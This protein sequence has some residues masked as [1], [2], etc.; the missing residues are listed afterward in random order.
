MLTLAFETSCDETAAAVVDSQFNVLSNV[1]SSQIDIHKLF[2]GVV[3]E[4][5]SRNHLLRIECVLEEALR[6]ANVQIGDISQIAA[7]VQPG[8]TG[9]VMV[10]RVFAESLSTAIG[11]PFI[12]VNHLNGHLASINLTHKNIQPPFLSLVVSGGHTSLYR[13]TEKGGWQ[14]ELLM[15][16]TDDACGEAF[17][18][19]GK[20]LGLPYP[21]GPHIAKLAASCKVSPEGYFKFASKMDYSKPVFSY[22]GLKTAVLNHVNRTKQ[23]NE[24]LDLS[25]IAASFQFEAVHQLVEKCTSAL[26][27]YKSDTLC[28][29]GGVSANEHLRTTM[30]TACEKSGARVF[31]PELQF[32]GDN[33]AMIA[34]AALL[35]KEKT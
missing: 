21:G 35:M 2:G 13:V 10:G 12:G 15:S 26:K 34:A 14:T 31:F 25:L 4:I 27:K 7:T 6:L 8:L 32:C 20:F 24:T 9:A 17:D 33:A 29:C 23:K 18:K 16:T 1:V 11:V 22:S 5:A 19:V 3:P 30:Q 28:V